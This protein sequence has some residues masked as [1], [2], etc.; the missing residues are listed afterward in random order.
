MQKKSWTVKETATPIS[1]LWQDVAEGVQ[2]LFAGAQWRATDVAGL[3]ARLDV[4][5]EP[6]RTALSRFGF[7]AAGE[8][9]VASRPSVDTFLS[10]M[11]SRMPSLGTGRLIFGMDA[12]ASR[13]ATWRRAIETQAEM[14]NSASSFG[15]LEVQLVY[16]R[17]LCEFTPSAWA[18][19]PEEI[20]KWMRAVEC[21]AGETQIR[22]VLKHALREHREARISALVYVGDS[23]EENREQ[24]FRL[25]GEAGLLGVPIFMFQE[26]TDETVRGIYQDIARHSGGAYAAFNA[27]SPDQLRE[28]LNAVAVY[29]SG[30]RRALRD[31]S[32]TRGDGVLRLLT[33]QVDLA[34][35]AC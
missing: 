18:N 13:Q 8:R 21:L 26:G 22:R 25:A 20:V 12:T 31:L 10:A 28:L 30:G 5:A 35:T 3:P 6:T 11:Q 17:G 27:A 15:G 9:A 14:F 34:Q 2:S 24:L 33:H 29:A 23:V 1:A 32:R 4:A 19:H 7:F 16:F